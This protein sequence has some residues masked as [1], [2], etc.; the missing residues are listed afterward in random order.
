MHH[1]QRE[2]R[3]QAT[4][5]ERPLPSVKSVVLREN[6][7]RAGDVSS[8]KASES[9]HWQRLNIWKQMTPNS[10]GSSVQTE[11]LT[12][13]GGVSV[14]VKSWCW[15]GLGEMLLLSDWWTGWEPEADWAHVKW[16]AF[17]SFSISIWE[18]HKQTNKQTKGIIM[19]ERKPHGTLRI[20]S[21]SL[22]TFIIYF[23]YDHLT[24]FYYKT[25]LCFIFHPKM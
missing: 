16:M 21:C 9:F 6:L 24:R 15:R 4:R 11:N 23:L 13:R 8:G 3:R 1:K 18:E 14:S 25:L 17:F 10:T 12:S 20:T 19:E 5:K 7:E 2:K 22:Q